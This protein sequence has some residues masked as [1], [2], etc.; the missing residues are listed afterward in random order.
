MRS[1]SSLLTVQIDAAINPGNSGGPAVSGGKVVGVAFQGFSQMQN[2]GYIVPFPVIRHFLNDIALHRRHTGFV[3]IGI[4]AQTMENEGTEKLTPPLEV[5]SDQQ[6]RV[7]DLQFQHP[8]VETNLL[9]GEVSL[10]IL[11]VSLW[12]RGEGNVTV[13]CLAMLAALKRSKG[14]DAIP[15]DALP[16]NVTAAGVLVVAV[17]KVRTRMYAQG[18]ISLPISRYS[19]LSSRDSAGERCSLKLD[20]SRPASSLVKSEPCK[21]A[22]FELLEDKQASPDIGPFA[23]Q[24]QVKEV[25][26]RV[27]WQPE[28]WKPSQAEI[29]CGHCGHAPVGRHSTITPHGALQ[30]PEEGVPPDTQPKQQVEL[31]AQQLRRESEA[32]RRHHKTGDKR[33]STDGKDSSLTSPARL[34]NLKSS[35]GSAHEHDNTEG[36]TTA[37]PAGVRRPEMTLGN[38]SQVTPKPDTSSNSMDSSKTNTPA[39][40]RTNA[41][42]DGIPGGSDGTGNGNDQNSGVPL[43]LKTGGVREKDET[44]NSEALAVSTSNNQ[45]ARS[46]ASEPPPDQGQLSTAR[47]KLEA[48]LY[49]LLGARRGLYDVR[50]ALDPTGYGSS[51]KEPI[52][53]KPLQVTRP[54]LRAGTKIRP[55]HGGLRQVSSHPLP[56]AHRGDYWAHSQEFHEPYTSPKAG[57]TY[58]RVASRRDRIDATTLMLHGQQGNS[59]VSGS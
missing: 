43:I 58:K 2:V 15:A 50:N 44:Q 16:E 38:E 1:S 57:R 51:D 7:S 8:A 28:G 21:V 9:A 33:S 30:N 48:L 19:P 32:V 12:Q 54:P 42:A 49:G 20:Q 4:K 25:D 34:S 11:H 47:A 53:G 40:S 26:A 13:A 55:E 6:R 17:D 3:S 23:K 29:S 36:P 18:K 39:A 10:S 52:S 24:R 59:G 27:I 14:M 5:L 22:T 37:E 41:S 46:S 35:I 31:E 45:A 56:G